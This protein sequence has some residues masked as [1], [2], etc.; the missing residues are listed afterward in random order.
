MIEDD[1][2]LLQEVDCED[3]SEHRESKAYY[4]IDGY[5]DYRDVLD[6]EA[7]FLSFEISKV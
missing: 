6:Y 4:A 2:N 7:E 1:F 3:V 5:V